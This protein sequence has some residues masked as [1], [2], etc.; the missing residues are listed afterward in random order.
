MAPIVKD[1]T[2]KQPIL[3]AKEEVFPCSVNI[4]LESARIKDS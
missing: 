3:T 4:V 1:Y 2:D